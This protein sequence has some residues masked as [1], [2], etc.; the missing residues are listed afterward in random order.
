MK[1]LPR[2]AEIEAFHWGQYRQSGFILPSM[3]PSQ[4]EAM[5][6]EYFRQKGYQVELTSYTNDYGVDCFASRGNERIAVQAK[7]YGRGTRSVNRMMVMELCGAMHYFDCTKAM[8]VTDGNLL[9]DAW[10]VAEKLGIEVVSLPALQDA[11][12]Q[13]TADDRPSFDNVWQK[14]IVPLK[15]RTLERATGKSNTIVSVDWTGVK[16]ITSTGQTQ[17]I[18]IEIFRAT[19]TKL[20]TEGKVPKEWINDHYPGRA[21]SGICLILSQVP[22]IQWDSQSKSLLWNP[23][24]AEQHGAR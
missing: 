23:N 7:M 14:Y 10:Q 18:K 3:T 15:G 22:E 21:S 8:L 5:V 16:R 17:K 12:W 24:E 11:G 13:P 4:Y 19:I 1:S 20:L 2:D 9:P 6:A